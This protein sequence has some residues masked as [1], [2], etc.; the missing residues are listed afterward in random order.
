MPGPV[1]LLIKGAAAV[2]VALITLAAI[3]P[4]QA[5]ELLYVYDTS[6]VHCREWER[7]IGPIYPKTEEAKIAPLRPVLIRDLPR[8]GVVLQRPVRYTPT[9]VLIEA[10]R[11]VGRIE[12]Y[13]GE[14]FFWV[15]LEQLLD[16][17]EPRAAPEPKLGGGATR[18]GYR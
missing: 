11:E 16:R 7:V 6:C 8:S 3:A 13:P 17:L 14:E 12:G 18:T 1:Q 9:F 4:T 15:R 5:A 10:D 2:V